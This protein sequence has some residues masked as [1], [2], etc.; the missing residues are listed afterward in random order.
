MPLLTGLPFSSFASS[1]QASYCEHVDEASSCYS[2]I[3]IVCSQM[4]ALEQPLQPVAYGPPFD[5][6]DADLILQSGDGKLFS[7]H[8]AVMFAASIFFREFPFDVPPPAQDRNAPSTI[9]TIPLVSDSAKDIAIFLR[10]IHDLPIPTRIDPLNVLHLF[11]MGRKYDAD[12]VTARLALILATSSLV[13]QD[14]IWA[15]AVGCAYGRKE[16][17]LISARASLSLPLET[18]TARLAA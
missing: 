7:V 9:A 11:D 5:K 12:V 14:P 3:N 10:L 18:V 1:S 15:Y 2:L 4:S 6:T 8:K 17:A 16:L 13:R